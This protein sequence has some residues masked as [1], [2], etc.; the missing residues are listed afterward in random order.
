MLVQKLLERSAYA[1]LLRRLPGF[2]PFA[3]AVVNGQERVFPMM[4]YQVDVH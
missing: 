3:R 2:T 1:P 4:E